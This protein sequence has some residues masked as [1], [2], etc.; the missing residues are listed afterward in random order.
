[1]QMSRSVLSLVVPV[2]NMKGEDP[3]DT[4]LLLQMW[5]EAEQYLSSFTWCDSIQHG[6]FGGGVGGV[7]A[8]FLVQIVPVRNADEWVWVVVGDV[9]FAYLVVDENPT[10]RD[11]LDGYIREMARWVNA[12][13]T[14]AN[15]AEMIPVNAPPTKENGERLKV[16]LDFLRTKVLPRLPQA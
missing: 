12:V 14:G 10:P 4:T 2:E 15:T 7:V 11:A 6:Y 13:E 5:K 9:P 8:V 3:E 1:M 16:R